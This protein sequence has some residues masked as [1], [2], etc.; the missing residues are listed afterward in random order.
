MSQE[1]VERFLGRIITD[2]DFRRMAMGSIKLAMADY[3]LSFTD[4][5]MSAVMAVDW[6]IIELVSGDLDKTIKRSSYSSVN[7]RHAKVV[8]ALS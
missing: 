5:E 6:D 4:E 1:S 3:G 7:Y 8:G 2:D